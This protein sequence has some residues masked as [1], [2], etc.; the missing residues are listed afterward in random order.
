MGTFLLFHVKQIKRHKS[1]KLN[2]VNDFVYIPEINQLCVSRETKGQVNII[3]RV[4]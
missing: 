1:V 3:S 2:F 4:I